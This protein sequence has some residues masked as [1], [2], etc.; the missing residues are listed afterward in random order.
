MLYS[1]LARLILL[2]FGLIESKK[3]SVKRYSYVKERDEETGLNYH[4]TRYYATL[5]AR[6]TACEPINNKLYNVVHG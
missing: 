3:C 1:W 5:I 2:V 6:L 4:G